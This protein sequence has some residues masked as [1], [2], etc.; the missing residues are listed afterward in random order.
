G[1]AVDNDTET[2]TELPRVGSIALVKVGDYK[3]DA[4]R[5]EV[6]D[7]IEYTFTVTN[8]GNVTVRELVI[9]DAKLGI[10]DLAVTPS[11]LAP[12]A[13]GTATAT[14]SIA[15]PDIESG[16]VT[17]TAIASGTSEAGDVEDTSGTA[18]DNDTETETELPRV[19]SIALVK[20][21]DY[22]GDA[23]RAEVGDAIEYTFT[24]TNT[25]NVTVRELVVN[26]GK[27][28]KI[29]RAACRERVEAVAVRVPTTKQNSR[30]GSAQEDT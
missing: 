28:G 11:T 29:G 13:M 21:G 3:G 30:A 25:G 22:Q 15:A 1:T 6:G 4:S 16:V 19:G 9:N 12:G 8:T 14:Y 26:D 10:V 7:E 5:A 24:V 2:E 18:I 27:L 17:N 20:T 23:S